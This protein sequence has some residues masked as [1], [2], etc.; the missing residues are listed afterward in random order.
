MVE[1]C[2]EGSDLETNDQLTKNPKVYI[3]NHVNKD[4]HQALSDE[5]LTYSK[6]EDCF[7]ERR[8]SFCEK[9]DLFCRQQRFADALQEYEEN[10]DPKYRTGFNTQ[11]LYTWDDVLD[12]VEDA[13]SK[14]IGMEM[15]GKKG[16]LKGMRQ[17]LRNF[18]KTAPAIRQWLKLLPEDSIY[19]SVLCGG[20]GLILSV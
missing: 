9:D 6:E 18:S 3:D 15:K 17:K 7:T 5:G 1:E 13:R 16:S 2:K 4:L 14:Y 10:V 12:R 11:N 20:L 19:A 8:D